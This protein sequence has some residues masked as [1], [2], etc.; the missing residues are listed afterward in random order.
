MALLQVRDILKQVCRKTDTII[1]WG[2]DEFLVVGR[3]M[4][5]DSA[6]HLAERIRNAVDAHRFELGIGEPMRLSCSVGFA[7]YPFL[8]GAPTLIGWEQVVTIAD[9]ALY[10]AKCSGRNAWAAIF[11]NDST[12]PDDLVHLINEQAEELVER[13]AL[14]FRTSIEHREDLVWERV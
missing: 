1:R 7:Q 14:D 10:L 2:G 4:D 9:R 13:G 5:L 8:P 12:P 11:G 6:E 3:S